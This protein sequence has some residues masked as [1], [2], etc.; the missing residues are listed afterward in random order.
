[1]A[2]PTLCVSSNFSYILTGIISWGIG[3]GLPGVPG[4]YASVQEALCF[5]DYDTN[6]KHGQK[7]YDYYDYP[8]CEDW[9]EKQDFLESEIIFP[10]SI[11]ERAKK[12]MES[13]IIQN[14]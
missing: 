3:C 2:G 9:I 10:K 8:Q 7:Y 1:M 11:A 5:I 13:C 12:L 14:Q 4:I 6:C